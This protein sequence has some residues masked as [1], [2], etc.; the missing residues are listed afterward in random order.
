MH[1]EQAKRHGITLYYNNYICII[2]KMQSWQHCCG[3]YVILKSQ[4]GV[5]KAS[6]DWCVE[7]G[8]CVTGERTRKAA[9]GTDGDRDQG[10]RPA[11]AGTHGCSESGVLAESH[12]CMLRDTCVG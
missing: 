5:L 11:T 6:S 8:W 3:V 7:S 12:V 10:Q 1:G 4:C 2:Y 9:Q